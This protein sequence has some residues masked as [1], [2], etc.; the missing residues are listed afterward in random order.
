[1]L[2]KGNDYHG[3]NKINNFLKKKKK[4]A[5]NNKAVQIIMKIKIVKM[6]LTILIF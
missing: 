2:I 1:M 6:F 5:I 3:L 4:N